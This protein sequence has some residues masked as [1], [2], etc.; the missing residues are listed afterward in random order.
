MYRNHPLSNKVVFFGQNLHLFSSCI[1]NLICIILQNLARVLIELQSSPTYQKNPNVLDIWDGFGQQSSIYYTFLLKSDREYKKM[2][3]RD[4]ELNRYY[5][6][7]GHR[8]TIR[9]L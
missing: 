7:Y 1:E 8:N 4:Q 2:Y 9:P 6:R 3:L 5:L